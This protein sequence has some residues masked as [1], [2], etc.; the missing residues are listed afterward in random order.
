MTTIRMMYHYEDGY[1]TSES[2]DLA[3]LTDVRWCSGGETYD[4]ARELAADGIPWML[5]RDDLVL[6]HFVPE[7]SIAQ[8]AAERAAAAPAVA[9]R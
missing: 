3:A 2:P 5:E 9:K 1:W 8:L 6:Q 4:E 7:S